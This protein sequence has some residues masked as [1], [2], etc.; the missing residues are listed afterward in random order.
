M[1]ESPSVG[2][3]LFAAI[4]ASVVIAFSAIIAGV[5]INLPS[6]QSENVATVSEGANAWQIVATAMIMALAPALAF[7]WGTLNGSNI[8]ELL[9][10]VL[11]TNSM[12]TFL[13]ILWSFS[14]AY[15]QDAKSNGILGYP[16]TYYFFHNTFDTSAVLN[17]SPYVSNSIF[18]VYELGFALITATFISISLA[19]R[20]NLN[21]FLI[22]MMCWHL[23]VYCPIAHVVWTPFGAIKTNFIQDWSGG[24]VVFVLSSATAISLHLVLG[25]DEIPKAGPVANPEKAL[26]LTFV[27]WF[28]WFGFIAGKAHNANAVACQTVVNL[29]AATFCSTLMSFFYNLV[30]EKPVTSV[31]LSNAIMIGLVGISSGA[32]Y[33][34]VGGAMVI[35]VFTYLFTAIIAQFFIGEGFNAHESFSTLTINAVAGSCG[36]LWTAI[37]SYHFINPSQQYP[38]NINGGP[39]VYSAVP[40]V[41]NYGAYNGLTSGRGIPLAYQIA[42]FL[43]VWAG[44]FFSTFV[45]AWIVNLISPLKHTVAYDADYKAPAGEPEPNEIQNQK[46]MEMTNQV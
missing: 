31:S 9:R 5:P 17:G 16:A 39:N 25:K 10:Q 38:S 3:R 27:V 35:S 15:G 24:L 36:F 45:L 44:A 33:V 26:Y 41:W 40:E 29:I 7:L 23:V 42:A 37:I 14:L 34:T 4:G 18:A 8:A 28:L 46:E 43:A 2:T 13:W 1:S 21:S 12:V 22:F 6:K 19:G 30:L 32:G 11:V 20:V